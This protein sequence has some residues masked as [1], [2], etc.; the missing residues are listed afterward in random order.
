MTS[1]PSR[2]LIMKGGG[3]YGNTAAHVS[4]EGGSAGEFFL[5]GGTSILRMFDLRGIPLW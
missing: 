1:L 3:F 4:S 5:N 2:S